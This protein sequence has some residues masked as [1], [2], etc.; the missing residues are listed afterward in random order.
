MK[1]PYCEQC[2]TVQ[3]KCRECMR[4][5]NCD[6]RIAKERH[7]IQAIMCLSGWGILWFSMCIL[8]WFS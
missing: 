1:Y 8:H 7:F 2:P 5:Y 6:R 3:T 4:R